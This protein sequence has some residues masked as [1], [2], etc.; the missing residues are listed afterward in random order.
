MRVNTKVTEEIEKKVSALLLRDPNYTAKYIKKEVENEFNIEGKNYAF[1]ERTY[2]NIKNR[3]LAHMPSENQLDQKW[4]I[5]ACRINNIP[6]DM[7]PVLLEVEQVHWKHVA[8]GE[9][10]DGPAKITVRQAIW[11]SIL[12]PKVN[13]LIERYKQDVAPETPAGNDRKYKYFS[14]EYILKW[15]L[16]WVA[17]MYAEQE[18]ISELLGHKYYDTSGID[19]IVFLRE[20]L[21]YSDFIDAIDEVSNYSFQKEE[22]K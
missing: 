19:E 4:S 13:A 20:H 7:I 3:I 9:R 14:K 2:I 17:V 1:T 22:T 15:M 5:G 11:M 10:Q 8:L 6:D 16:Y 21:H 12:R 18:Q